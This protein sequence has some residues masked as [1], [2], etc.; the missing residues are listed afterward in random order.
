MR[1]HRSYLA[2]LKK[3][4][5]AGIVRGMAHITGGGITENLPRILPRG[6][7]AVVD[8]ASWTVPPLFEHLRQ[9]GDVEQD[10][11][12]RT[13]NMGIGMIV[14]VSAED[15]KKAKAVL[16]RANERFHI[17]GRITRGDRRVSYN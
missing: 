8:L 7:A 3:L 5:G 14:V 4:C 17:I 10:E 16:N 6:T 12:M 2:I 1:T 9:L 15:V 11:M 13:F